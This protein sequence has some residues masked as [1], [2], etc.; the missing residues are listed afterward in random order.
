MNRFFKGTAQDYLRLR[1]MKH[2]NVYNCE[3]GAI[4]LEKLANGIDLM[5]EKLDNKKGGKNEQE[6]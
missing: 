2:R 1:A 5:Q 3:E 4:I 6:D